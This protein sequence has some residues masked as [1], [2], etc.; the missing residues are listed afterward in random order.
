M[1]SWTD[2][3]IN[4]QHLSHR[5]TGENAANETWQWAKRGRLKTETESLTIAAQDQTLRTKYRRAKMEKSTGMSMC[6]LC[7]EKEETVCHIV[8]E[9][10]KITQSTK[11]DMTE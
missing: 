10:S 5:Q 8:S 11:G 3:A 2:K 7:K 6:R 4:G 1:K 9:C